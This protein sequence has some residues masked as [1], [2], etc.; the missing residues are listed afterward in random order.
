MTTFNAPDHP[1]LKVY[2]SR[3]RSAIVFR[4]G[5]VRTDDPAE[6]A[7]LRAHP[8]VTEDPTKE[9]LL[10]QARDLGIEGRSQMRK[11]ELAEA[12]DEAQPDDESS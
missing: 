5:T 7:L 11:E 2:D 4:N 12:V 1:N 6:I 8:H 3:T 9:V 10:E